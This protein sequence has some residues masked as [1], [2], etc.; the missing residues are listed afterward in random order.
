MRP[1]K[2]WRCEWHAVTPSYEFQVAQP[3]GSQFKPIYFKEAKRSETNLG[4]LFRLLGC[5]DIHVRER[6]LL[7][8]G[9]GEL[10]INTNKGKA[11]HGLLWSAAK[12]QPQ[13]RSPKAAEKLP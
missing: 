11:E 9:W 7:T 3:H 10:S 5:Q 1:A 13:S 12:W 4:P 2:D 8:E 6:A